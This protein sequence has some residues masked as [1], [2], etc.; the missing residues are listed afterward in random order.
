MTRKSIPD[1]I[2]RKL[3]AE[4]MGRCMNPNCQIEL[5]NLD[6]DIAE[7]AHIIPYSETQDNSFENLIMLC[8]NC[9]TNFDKNGGFD[10]E[11]VKSWKKI[12]Q[13]EIEKYFSKRFINFDELRKNIVPILTEN[14][15]IYKNYFLDE[16]KKLWDKFE[17]KLLTNNEKL[18]KILES[19]LE[20]IQHHT[21]SDYSN[22][23]IVKNFIAHI[24][25]FAIT[26]S[27]EE[28]HRKILFPKEI[29]SIF[30]IE[31]IKDNL[32]PSTESLEDLIE[33]LKR[34]GVF[35]DLE[36]G[37]DRPFI[38]L[39]IEEHI[40]NIYLDDA[41][42]LRQLYY[43]NH[44]FRAPKVRLGSLNFAMK[45][46]KSRGIP[47]SYP[48]KSKVREISI[49]NI[50]IFFVYEYCLSKSFLEEMLPKEES[51]IVNLHNWNGES[52]IS[53]EAYELSKKL[54][55]TLLSMDDF[56]VF[57]NKLK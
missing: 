27:E 30:G 56:Y 38:T 1:N 7:Q 28:K 52:C 48:N 31:P 26:R 35:Y 4:S 12:R 19:N 24:N 25:E 46:I 40:E 29:N 33:K 42:R 49:K 15:D 13:E 10:I 8:P 5:F 9:H 21:N 51:V 20:L 6:G 53:S 2:K 17:G 14:Q 45:Y 41:P 36:L 18:K 16:N 57:I 34:K 11:T 39:K 3:W 50:Q 22:R 37:V 23:T 55:V 47:F 32:I 43:D 54:N 44:S